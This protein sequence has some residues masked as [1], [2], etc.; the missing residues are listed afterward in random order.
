MGFR[1]FWSADDTIISTELSGLKTNYV[2]NDNERVKVVITESGP[3]SK[4]SQIQEFLDYNCGP[5]VQHIALNTNDI[6][7]TVAKLR[8][9]GN[10]FLAFIII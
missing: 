2:T 8:D 7:D 6:C 9:R 10:D 3:G 1:R 4:R 5:G